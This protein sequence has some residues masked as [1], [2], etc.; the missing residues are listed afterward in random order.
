VA[1]PRE[2]ARAPSAP[3]GLPAPEPMA[4]TG[5][6][7]REASGARR[8]AVATRRRHGPSLLEAQAG[9]LAVE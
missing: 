6:A 3:L 4:A 9:E 7:S 8:S 1:G 2:M 5:K